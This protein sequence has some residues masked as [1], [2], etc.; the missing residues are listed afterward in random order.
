MRRYLVVVLAACFALAVPGLASAEQ[1][2]QGSQSPAS[3]TPSTLPETPK[4][5]PSDSHP[6]EPTPPGDPGPD[7][8]VPD[9]PPSEEPSTDPSVVPSTEP[10]QDPTASRKAENKGDEAET[11]QAE[12][13]PGLFVG[14]L[15][16]VPG[17]SLYV[18]GQGCEP[19]SKATIYGDGTKLGSIN[20]VGNGFI[21]VV[22]VPNGWE[23][24]EHTISAKCPG[25]PERLSQTVT[26]DPDAPA[27][28]VNVSDTTVKPGQ[29]VKVSGGVCAEGTDADALDHSTGQTF[30]PFTVNDKGIFSGTFT[31]PKNWGP[32]SVHPV[33][34][35]CIG[36]GDPH[37]LNGFVQFKVPG[38]PE[39]PG[40][41]EDKDNEGELKGDQLPFTGAAGLPLLLGAGAA[42]IAAGALL[43]TVRRRSRSAS[44][45][46][47]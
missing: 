11:L 46:V 20:V 9:V 47:T 12:S 21:G 30:G 36:E 27:P 2:E 37:V 26:V 5:V 17:Q 7:P 31:V 4:P 25:W 43:L 41:G 15:V 34:F 3:D 28:F 40:K 16:L 45:D 38:K 32:G 29:K 10:G 22:K 19:G 18:E 23:E 35:A 39:P 14:A 24:G 6:S 42:L 13:E 1:T 8:S 33:S 44:N